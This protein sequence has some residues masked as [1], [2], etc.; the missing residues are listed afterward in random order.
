MLHAGLV[1][2]IQ[3]LGGA[4]I[5]CATSELASNGE[6]GMHVWLDRVLLRDSSLSPEEIL[7]SESQERMC[8]VV[9]PDN[10]DAFMAICAKWDVE[11]V[12]IGE[13]NDSG[14]LTDRLPR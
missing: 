11:A 10:I 13:V 14:R 6:G 9:S 2:G 12:V 1:E 8:A 7:M 3:D 4:G 5:S